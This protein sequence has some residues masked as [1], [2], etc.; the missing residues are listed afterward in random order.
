MSKWDV[1]LAI[2]D[3]SELKSLAYIAKI[4][5]MLKLYTIPVSVGR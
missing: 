5:S 2:L 1:L 4:R 3:F